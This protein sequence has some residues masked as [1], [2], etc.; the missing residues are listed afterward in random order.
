LSLVGLLALTGG[1]LGSGCTKDSAE[2]PVAATTEGGVPIRVVS[3]ANVGLVVDA[4][5]AAVDASGAGAVDAA[6][7]GG[8]DAAAVDVAPQKVLSLLVRY[9]LNGG[10]VPANEPFKPALDVDVTPP[11]GK[12]DSLKEVT[13]TLTRTLPMRMVVGEVKLTQLGQQTLPETGVTT[14]KVGDTP[15]AIPNAAS[16]P[17]EV[18]LRA[19]SAG[20]AEATETVMFLLDA[21]PEIRVDSPMEGKY[22][23]GS[24]PVDVT[25]RDQYFGPVSAIVATVAGKEVKLAG[26]GGPSGTQYTA[27]VDFSAFDPRLK[28]PVGFTV[29]AQNRNKTEARVTRGFISDEEGPEITNAIPKKGALIGRVITISADVSDPA[30]VLDSSVVAVVAHGGT[31]FEVRLNPPPPGSVRK[32]FS[33]TFDTSRLPINALFPT[34]S[35]RASDLLGNERVEGYT[36]ALDN[37]PPQSDLD[38]PDVRAIF[39]P[40]GETGYRC[41]W[42]FDPVGPDA[43]DDGDTVAQLFDVRARIED[44]GNT[45]LSGTADYVPVATIG[46]NDA[47]LLIL[48]DHTVPLVVNTNPPVAGMPGKG[49]NACDAINPNIVPSTKP[50]SSKDALLITMVP[51]VAGGLFDATSGDDSAAA[52][53]CTPGNVLTPAAEICSTTYNQSKARYRFVGGS[54]ETRSHVTTINMFYTA[55]KANSSSVWGLPPYEQRPSLQCGGT[56]F[57]ALANNI[58]DGWACL[59][60]LAQDKLGNSQVS[61]PLRVC[62]DKDGAGNECPHKGITKVKPSTPIEVETGAP[63]GLV[64]GDS[65]RVQGVW[66]QTAANGTWT[67]QVIDPT[68]F[69]LTG[70]VGDVRL[71]EWPGTYPQSLLPKSLGWVVK[72]SDVPNCT[73]TVTAAG[74]P[75]VV[76]AKKPCDPWRPYPKNELWLPPAPP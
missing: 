61:R 55:D 38:P 1:P 52:A 41:S 68:H 70:S 3:D 72:W 11:P 37:N 24:L 56:Q 18:T 31:T 71:G 48:D 47:K 54:T 76:D 32:E 25:I 40:N 49:D 60:V 7:G 44:R 64:S 20:G 43:V 35:F 34:I 14:Y 75:A 13:A 42:P 63:H 50:M 30:G 2:Y 17:Y 5:V 28:G 15:I 19:I 22:F 53:L 33:A 57:D 62:I 69:T 74:P 67:V 27:T 8:M 65:V 12:L 6:T 59:A 23:R 39:I 26:P 73:G 16:G 51:F 36:V 58:S 21:G 4:P 66:L 45:P 46:M 9:P 10:V 29:R